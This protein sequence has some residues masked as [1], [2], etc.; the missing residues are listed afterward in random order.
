MIVIGGII[1]AG[2]T[3]CLKTIQESV[4]L[5][6]CIEERVEVWNSD[7]ILTK[8]YEDM[9]KYGSI[10]QDTIIKDFNGIYQK[11]KPDEIYLF[12]RSIWDS[13]IVF[14]CKKASVESKALWLSLAEKYIPQMYIFI[15]TPVLTCL[16]RINKRHREGELFIR[17]EYLT[18][19][20]ERNKHLLDILR[21]K[22]CIIEIVDGTKDPLTVS[23]DIKDIINKYIIK[24]NVEIALRS[25]FNSS[26]M[27]NNPIYWKEKRDELESLSSS[28]L[29]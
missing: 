5:V 17:I 28:R 27:R 10:L 19:L 3:T 22:K 1:G 29:G 25:Y 13:L 16:E 23:N 14:E 24:N 11:M 8:F 7:N 2:K 20:N 21:Q 15:D 9:E 6:K 18:L 26:S 4:P 12:E